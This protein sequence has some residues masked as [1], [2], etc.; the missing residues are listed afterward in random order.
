[1]ATPNSQTPEDLTADYGHSEDE[2]AATSTK[3][4]AVASTAT[5]PTAVSRTTPV[6]VL[7]PAAA[8]PSPVAPA[9]PSPVAPAAAAPSPMAPAAAAPSTADAR[10]AQLA[11]DAEAARKEKQRVT[12]EA[13]KKKREDA[14]ALEAEEAKDAKETLDRRQQLEISKGNIPKPEY[15]PIPYKA[16]KPTSLAEQWGSTA[17]MFAMLGSLFTRNHAVTA[18]NAAAGAMNGFKEG[19]E[20]AAKQAKEEF[21]V[22]N[23]NLLK[24]TEFQQKVY[25]EAMKGI[26]TREE[27]EKERYTARGKERAAKLKAIAAAFEDTT[28]IAAMKHDDAKGAWEDYTRNQKLTEDLREKTE[29]YEAEQ[30]FMEVQSKWT[31]ETPIEDKI[32]QARATRSKRGD[33]EA[34]K[35]E[36]S[37]AAEQAKFD[38]G[39]ET[40]EFKDAVAAKDYDKQDE[41]LEALGDKDAAR[42][43]LKRMTEESKKLTPEVKAQ[44]VDDFKNMKVGFNELSA[45]QKRMPQYIEAFQQAEKE[46][47]EAG[48]TMGLNESFR[49]RKRSLD[50][51]TTGKDATTIRSLNVVHQHLDVLRETFAEL[52]QAKNSPRLLNDIA[53]KIGRALNY[54]NITSYDAVKKVLPTELQ[55]AISGAGIGTGKERDEFAAILSS[56]LNNKSFEGVVNALDKLIL[57]QTIGFYDQYGRYLAVEDIFPP[58]V[59]G[60]VRDYIK[61]HRPSRKLY[62]EPG[63][64]T[65]GGAAPSGAAPGG[66]APGNANAPATQPKAA[67][68][69]PKTPPEKYP[70]AQWSEQYNGWFVPDPARPGKYLQVQ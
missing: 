64:A 22:A 52:K 56:G 58:E 32:Q 33:A 15:K 51:I 20:A 49:E 41:I 21:K 12:E 25:A 26:E 2:D 68:P 13:L 54:E 59:A 30:R 63:G 27:F 40:Q 14:A 66:A 19:N 50:A 46:F 38:R 37:K 35:L 7:A 42:R 5:T 17:M 70:N 10:G 29:T 45:A 60:N 62:D 31:A 3:T 53:A 6:N 16:P 69:Q 67:A 43:R 24:A 48:H 39:R 8:A 34:L 28:M 11:A 4:P 57:G 36:G 61:K 55:K 47:K 65:P 9:A 1:M 23:E 44:L 18:L